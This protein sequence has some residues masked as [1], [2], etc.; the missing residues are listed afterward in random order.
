MDTLELFQRLS[1]SLAIGLVIGLERGWHARLEAE[2]ERAAGLRTLAL[3]GILGGVWGAIAV[4]GG[5]GGMVA[6]AV[7]FAALSAVIGTYRLRE[8]AKDGTFGATTVVAA[9]LAFAL[10]AFAVLGDV[11]VAAA[12]GV[13]AAGLLAL[14]GLLHDWLSRLSWVELRSGLVL[15]AMT[16]VLLPLLPNRTVDPWGAINPFE[17][18]LMTILI[19]ALSFAG[20]AAIKLVG[21]R[22]G[23]LITGVGGG[24]VSSTVVTLNMARLAREH[25]E[26]RNQLVASAI[27][28]SATMMARVLFVVGVVNAALIP[29]LAWPLGFAGAA[30]AGVA[31]FLI[32]R[33]RAGAERDSV[34]ALDNPFELSTVLKFGALLTVIS[35]LA[36]AVTTRAGDLGAY[37]LAA[38]S[39]IADVDAI[40]LSMS[41][42]AGGPLGP[43]V[44]AHAIAIAVAVNTISK[45][46]IGWVAGGQA[47]GLMLAA[48]SAIALL[49][50]LI[51]VLVAAPAQLLAV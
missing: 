35:V 8:S 22:R 5:D 27:I 33:P 12:L 21:A 34:L 45:T 23:A 13:T 36:N 31:L 15:L 29:R 1:V 14:K 18:W 24:L 44:A 46:V 3:T 10:G 43:A 4:K 7:A 6:L 17:L 11:Q 48:A 2:G 41:R 25:P 38:F 32:W 20:Y 47:V 26:D 51:G 30:L 42:L 37:A 16:F 50:G 28:A 49:A 40:S 39:G 19:A 9:M